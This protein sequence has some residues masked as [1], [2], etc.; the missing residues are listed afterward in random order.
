MSY[1]D[2]ESPRPCVVVELV[3]PGNFFTFQKEKGEVGCKNTRKRFF[4][5]SHLLAC[6]P[7]MT[8]SSQEYEVTMQK[9][10]FMFF[11]LD[12][13]GPSRDL[14]SEHVE[15]LTL[16]QQFHVAQ[17]QMEAGDKRFGM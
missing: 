11:S 3:Y 7:R 12:L 14:F 13:M 17:R 2:A 10:F 16:K 15:C 1:S 8:Q 5:F 9:G 4:L 6:S